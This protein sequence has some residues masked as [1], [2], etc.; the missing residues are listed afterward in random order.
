M[1]A[2]GLS[3]YTG[4]IFEVKVNNVAIGSISGGGRYDNLTGTFGLEGVS[5]VGFSFGVD[6]I[7]DVME[8]LQLFP[9]TVQQATQ[10]LFTNFDEDTMRYSLPLL[11]ALRNEGIRAEMYPEASKLKKQL[12]YA[13]AKQIPFV[14]L[15]GEEERQQQRLGLKNMQTGEQQNYTLDEVVTIVKQA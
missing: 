14:I 13:N 2:R 12:N 5:G 9:E 7:F 6:R 4:A 15:I 10:V 1:L 3:Y 11:Q 8:E